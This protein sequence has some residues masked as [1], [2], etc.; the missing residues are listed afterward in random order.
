MLFP[1]ISNSDAETRLI[2]ESLGRLLHP[3]DI[4]LIDGP[5]GAGKTTF[6]RAVASGLGLDTAAV[7]SPTFVIAHQY[8]Q[9][10]ST[11]LDRPDLIHIDAYRLR[12]VEDLDSL[13]WDRLVEQ[14]TPAPATGLRGAA[15]VIEWAERLAGLVPGLPPQSTPAHIRIDHVDEHT[16][17]F[18]FDVPDP[19]SLRPNFASLHARGTTTCPIT[20]QPVPPDSPTYPFASERAR[21]ADLYRWFRGSYNISRDAKDTDFDE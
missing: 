11:P 8:Q 7:A 18:A 3:G 16:R 15:M 21:M 5:L 6:I 17:Q 4:I 10:P 19:W 20:G 14:T 12:G 9:S 1:R 13:G 2:G